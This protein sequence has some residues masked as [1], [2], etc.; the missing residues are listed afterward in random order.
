LNLWRVIVTF[1]LAGAAISTD[2][3]L[4]NKGL[5]EITVAIFDLVL[6]YAIL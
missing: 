1:A 6:I 5:V 3:E 4:W 2:L